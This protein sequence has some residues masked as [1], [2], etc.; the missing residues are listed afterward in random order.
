MWATC[1]L[2]WQ[3]CTAMYCDTARHFDTK[4]AL[5]VCVT[6]QQ[7]C[8]RFLDPTQGAQLYMWCIGL[9]SSADTLEQNANKTTAGPGQQLEANSPSRRQHHPK[10]TQDVLESIGLLSLCIVS[11][12]A[13]CRCTACVEACRPTRPSALQTHMLQT[14]KQTTA[15]HKSK[16]SSHARFEVHRSTKSCFEAHQT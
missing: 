14:N 4:G 12:K 2:L 6:W 7:I 9:G 5:H 1:L 16:G 11:R 8:S 15:K 13:E 3:G 10:V